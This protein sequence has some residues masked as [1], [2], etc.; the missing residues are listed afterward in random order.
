MSLAT[1]TRRLLYLLHRWMGVAACVLMALW[2]VSGI[3]MLF[4][5]YPKL[6]PW[7]RLGALPPLQ[8]ENCCIPL[9]RALT[10]AGAP[11]K[12]AVLTSID[13]RPFY[14]LQLKDG[15]LIAIDATTGAPIVIDT[16]RI[17]ASARTFLPQ[18]TAQDHGM[19]QEDRWTHGRALDPHRPLRM[20]EM[21]DPDHTR[22]YLSSVTGEV[23][24]DAPRAQRAWNYVGAWLHWLYYFRDRPVDPGWNWI[25]IVLSALGTLVA[26]SGTVVGV[27]RWRFNGRYKSGNRSPYRE[28]W[29]R[30]HHV[31]GLGFAAIIFTWIFSGLMS[32]NPLG[33]FDAR[34][35]KPD[36]AAWRNGDAIAERLP[37][38]ASEAISMLS[39]AG[40]H[41]VEIGWRILD[42]QPYLLARN[43]TGGTRL[44]ARAN[45]GVLTVRT[46]WDRATLLHAAARLMPSAIAAQH[47]LAHYDDYYYARQPESMMGAAERRLPVLHIQF[48]DPHATC[49]YVDPFTG[50]VVLSMDRAQRVGRWLFNFLHS[51]DLPVMLKSGIGRDIVLILLSLGGLAMSVTGVV[52]GCNRLRT[53]IAKKGK[54][55]H[56][57]TQR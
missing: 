25:V 53:W 20:V 28:S 47:E 1:R 8:A 15:R 10:A 55:R 30:W 2:F 23:V 5:G 36:L 39:R 9:G 19:V 26:I 27:W 24:L 44:V 33:V 6:T 17:L 32:M 57:V 41:P 43:A 22:L 37:L 51:W 29:L 46:Q 14:R 40:F 16:S 50:E 11:V 38:E 52:I 56:P 54:K 4:V 35:P 18:V 45:D 42:G 21:D 31:L 48:A 12:D 49:A 3:V 13:T 34:G 7:E